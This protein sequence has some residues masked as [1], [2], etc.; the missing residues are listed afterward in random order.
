MI[1]WWLA[2]SLVLPDFAIF[3]CQL[4]GT[5]SF[6]QLF[7]VLRYFPWFWVAGA[8][9]TSEDHHGTA[10][11]TRHRSLE[12]CCVCFSGC[13]FRGNL[14]IIPFFTN[15]TGRPRIFSSWYRSDTWICRNIP[16][17]ISGIVFPIHSQTLG[18]AECLRCVNISIY[19]DLLVHAHYECNIKTS[20]SCYTT[21]LDSTCSC[22]GCMYICVYSL[23]WVF[24]F[25]LILLICRICTSL[26]CM[27]IFITLASPSPA[28][29]GRTHAVAQT[30]FSLSGAIGPACATSLVAASVQYNLLGGSLAYVVMG[31][32]GFAAL[33]LASLLP[34]DE[35][36]WYR[37]VFWRF[38]S[39]HNCSNKVA[40]FG[41]Q[42]GQFPTY[43]K[44]FLKSKFVPTSYAKIRWQQILYIRIAINPT[45]HCKC[46]CPK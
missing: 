4:S 23:Q 16:W 7:F 26:G 18:T 8:P 41:D 39:N 3:K 44:S 19:S 38:P 42:I 15:P 34:V 14:C 1:P 35:L 37:E 33:G 46:Y 28:A 11:T 45:E 10:S 36:Q 2:S 20:R 27:Y 22:G 9:F 29:L 6:W 40:K 30:V 25:Q 24:Y 43:I 13:I 32:V 17:N 12:L 31:T 5:W 21:S